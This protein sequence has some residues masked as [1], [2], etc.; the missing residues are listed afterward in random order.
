[1]PIITP[2]EVSDG[3]YVKIQWEPLGLSREDAEKVCRVIMA[4]IGEESK[5]QEIEHREFKARQYLKDKTQ[6]F[7][8]DDLVTTKVYPQDRHLVRRV[9][10]TDS[11]RHC[12][13][14]VMVTTVDHQ[15]RT[16]RADAAWYELYN[17]QK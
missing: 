4:H 14:G 16:L 9:I 11:E 13:S 10:K 17:P 2:I 1:M 6:M 3:K 8:I 5:C 12:Q 15:G 7:K